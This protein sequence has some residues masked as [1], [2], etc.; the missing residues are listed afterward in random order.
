MVSTYSVYPFCEACISPVKPYLSGTSIGTSLEKKYKNDHLFSYYDH[1]IG[2][3]KLKTISSQSPQ[4]LHK[5]PILIA[6]VL[7]N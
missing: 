7:I 5:K 6:V 4:T 1:E 2:N 3:R